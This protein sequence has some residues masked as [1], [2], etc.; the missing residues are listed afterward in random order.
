MQKV[1]LEDKLSQFTDYWN[2]RIVGELNSQ[3]VKL[4]KLKGPFV[5]H[6]HE[7]EDE[8]F[9]VIKGRLAMEFRDKTAFLDPGEFIIV[10]RGTAHRPVAEE[11]VWVMLFEP[12]GTLNTGN[13]E[14]DFTRKDLEKI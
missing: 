14:N 11:E 6:Q 3:H 2:P 10:P 4:V 7:L 12:A 5:W 13:Q 9:F 1:N 8:M